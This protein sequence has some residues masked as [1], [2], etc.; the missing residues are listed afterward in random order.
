MCVCSAI[1]VVFFILDAK[2]H[3]GTYIVEG[4]TNSLGYGY[5][6][7]EWEPVRKPLDR[8][9]LGKRGDKVAWDG[10][11]AFWGMFPC[12]RSEYQVVLASNSSAMEECGST[13]I[14]AWFDIGRGSWREFARPA[15]EY[16]EKMKLVMTLR[17]PMVI[18]T[19][20]EFSET[21][22]D[23][24][25][26]HGLLDRTSMVTMTTLRCSPVAHLE[27]EVRGVMCDPAYLHATAHP[28]TPE[29]TQ[30]WYNLIMWAKAYL[31]KAGSLMPQTGN[32]YYI[33]LGAC[34]GN[35]ILVH[36]LDERHA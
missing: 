27:T 14:T 16:L 30:V 34:R 13:I 24:R 36:Y 19:T 7:S 11:A 9:D 21:I 28:E 2:G 29:R 31:F 4:V 35:R 23:M 18:F 32:G 26:S 3:T 10:D 1:I 8:L 33:W 15:S 20:P 22:L 5:K 17:N 6:C 25:A 12:D